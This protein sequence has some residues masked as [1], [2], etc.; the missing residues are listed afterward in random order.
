MFAE[1]ACASRPGS[2]RPNEDLVIAGPS[3]I[4]VAASTHIAFTS[5][6]T[7]NSLR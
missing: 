1:V 3:W 2:G 7:R 4:V 5:K 6:G